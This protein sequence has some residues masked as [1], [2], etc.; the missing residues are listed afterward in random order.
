MF[1][2]GIQI[3][4]SWPEGLGVFVARAMCCMRIDLA[5]KAL[6][7]HTYTHILYTVL[8]WQLQPKGHYRSLPPG[9]QTV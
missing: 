2:R 8:K 6:L 7:T 3:N 9:I 1:S 5:H 4:G